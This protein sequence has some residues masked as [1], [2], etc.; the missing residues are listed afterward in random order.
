MTRGR[1]GTGGL[2]MVRTAGVVV[3]AVAALVP[4][5]Y[6]SDF[7]LPYVVP[8][9]LLLRAAVGLGAGMLLWGA[10][11]ARVTAADLRDPILWSLVALTAV[12]GAAALAGPSPRHSLVG[13]LQRMWGS[14]QWAYLTVLYLV[15]RTF[16]RDA[17][18][19]LLL[20]VA[21][22]VAVGVAAFAV[23]EFAV[24]RA[25]PMASGQGIVS[26]LGNRGYLGAYMLLASGLAVVV[27]DRSEGPAPSAARGAAAVGLFGVVLL[28]SGS[29][30]ALA[31]GLVGGGVAAALL[32]LDRSRRST[33]AARWTAAGLAAVA[34]VTG[35]IWLVA[36]EALLEVP[37]LE[38]VA[39]IDPA[40]GGL[41]ARFGAWKAGVEGWAA[42][43]LTGWGMEN[44]SLVYDRFAD[45]GM[46]RVNPET[47]M[48]WDRPHNVLV[49]NLV[50]SGP[51]GTVAYLAVWASLFAVGARGWRTGR[52]GTA[53]AAALLGALSGYLV[54]LQ[55]WFEDHSTAFV[56]VTL[57]AY[58][59]HRCAGQPLLELKER[60]EIDRS[61]AVL[62]GAACLGIVTVTLW[63]SGR[64]GLAAWHMYRADAARGLGEAV[65]HYE[66]A[67]RLAVPEER[68]VALEYASAMGGLGLESGRTI[69]DSD[70]LRALYSRGVEGADRA[71]APVARRN[72]LDARTDAERGRLA[73]GAA[74]VFAEDRV[75]D[76]ARQSLE[77]AIEKSPALL[78]HRH[79]LAS[80]EALFGNLEQARR[81]LRAALEVYDGHGRT[82]Y[83]LS[84]M[85]GRE[86]DSTALRRLRQS[87]WLDY[88]PEDP[89]HV[90]RTV[91]ALLEGGRPGEAERLLTVYVASRYLP[92][93]RRYG[94]PFGR[95]REEF[96]ASR[97]AAIEPIGRGGAPHRIRQRDLPLLALWPR[98][99]ATAGGCRRAALAMSVLINGLSERARTASLLPTLSGQLSRLR[100]RCTG[101]SEPGDR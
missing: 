73:A 38:R 49:G 39:R 34:L 100:N 44:F 2:E 46:H 33:S 68:S 56:L 59:R 94:D 55:F 52:L 57:A 85:T 81:E 82:Y 17:E 61:R 9:A 10:A 65:S 6:G 43:P 25:L 98:A 93:L 72:P 83:L 90:R 29:R 8:R 35:G 78:E 13:D 99:A 50:H 58:L 48:F 74:V 24:E 26:T 12:S 87:F 22:Y 89:S 64:T 23:L 53:E 60:E 66:R 18:W 62:W 36:P 28:L 88:L 42:R 71:L 30:A 95:E 63:V 96:L 80:T 5:A 77:S 27:A 31:G 15:M 54:Y 97:T 76:L 101:G 86:V 41:A 91:T 32:L 79:R 14:V 7:M 92:Q 45:P 21:L 47:R 16:L 4:L 1:P 67:R 75:R 51:V 19:R 40:S 37:V 11:S 70:S 84:R 3:L 20:R 69:R